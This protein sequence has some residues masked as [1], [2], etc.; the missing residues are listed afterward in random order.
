MTARHGCTD[1][2]L[3]EAGHMVTLAVNGRYVLFQVMD[4]GYDAI[5][6]DWMLAAG[7]A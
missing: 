7:G 3:R 6:L 5:V 4:D 1:R 2:G